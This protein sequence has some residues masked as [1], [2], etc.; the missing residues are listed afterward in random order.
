MK[1]NVTIIPATKLPK[2]FNVGIYCRVS[3]TKKAQ[4]KSLSSQI[5]GLT[6]FVSSCRRY[7]LKDIYI[8]FE[9]GMDDNR[10]GLK[11]M[12]FDASRGLIDLIVV[13]SPSRLG[14]NTA[15]VLGACEQLKGYGC[16]VLFQDSDTLYSD[17]H[18]SLAISITCAADQAE[19]ESRS[20][21]TRWGIKQ[22]LIKGTSGY[23]TRP[24][25]GY[26]KVGDDLFPHEDEAV[27][28]RKIYNM[29][30]NGASIL[31]I[32]AELETQG[33]KTPTGKDVW[34]KKTIEH[35]LI[36]KRYTGVAEITFQ[37][38]TSDGKPGYAKVI[39][40]HNN[41]PIIDPAIFDAVQEEMKKRSN[42]EVAPDGTKTRK[43]TRYSVKKL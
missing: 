4:L 38:T 19:N 20:A 18:A 15:D 43:H 31:K 27:I 1:N 28:V 5:S 12:M 36:N 35:I 6:L 40:E 30:L 29:Y 7:H 42:I 33:Y 17:G 41:P 14:R 32:K 11:R 8:D 25:F 10:D 26:R 22:G 34:P 23:Y 24:F 21:N 9:S 3:S 16:D 39:A 37:D 2:I 13:K